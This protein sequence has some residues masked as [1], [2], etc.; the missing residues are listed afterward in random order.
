MSFSYTRANLGIKG[1]SLGIY[2]ITEKE[3]LCFHYTTELEKVS[4]P[5]MTF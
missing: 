4:Y 2:I 5:V 3:V 1:F